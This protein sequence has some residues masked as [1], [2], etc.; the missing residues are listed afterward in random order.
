MEA[1]EFNST[2]ENSVQENHPNRHSQRTRKPIK[3]FQPEFAQVKPKKP[4]YAV[5]CKILKSKGISCKL[6]GIDF[7]IASNLPAV[8]VFRKFIKKT[9]IEQFQSLFVYYCEEQQSN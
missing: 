8:S 5:H 1:N 2:S 4:E 9:R 6:K 3:V 7:T